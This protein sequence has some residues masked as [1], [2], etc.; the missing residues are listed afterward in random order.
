MT[1]NNGYKGYR[2][3]DYNFGVW[4][5][6]DNYLYDISYHLYLFSDDN[7]NYINIPYDQKIFIEMIEIGDPYCNKFLKI[8]KSLI[9]KEKLNIINNLI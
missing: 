4:N 6:E 7:D 9:R 1:K 2:N 8:A 3:Y 5:L